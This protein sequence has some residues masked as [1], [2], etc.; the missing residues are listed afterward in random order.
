MLYLVLGR[1]ALFT[2]G[3]LVGI[4]LHSSW[5]SQK[6]RNSSKSVFDWKEKV[7]NGEGAEYTKVIHTPVHYLQKHILTVSRLP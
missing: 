6:G 4:L 2:A 5:E 7:D 1:L 3:T